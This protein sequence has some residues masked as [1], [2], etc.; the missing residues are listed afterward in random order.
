MACFVDIRI[1]FVS[2]RRPGFRGKTDTNVATDLTDKDRFAFKPHRLYTGAG[3]C[4]RG[5]RGVVFGA[6]NP[7][8]DRKRTVNSQANICIAYQKE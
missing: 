4:V 1:D 6:R 8:D 7:D 2:D 5:Y 3:G